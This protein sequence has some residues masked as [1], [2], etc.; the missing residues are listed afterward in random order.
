MTTQSERSDA[1]DLQWREQIDAI[2]D[3][4]ERLASSLDE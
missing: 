4:L 2:W 3:E 1:E